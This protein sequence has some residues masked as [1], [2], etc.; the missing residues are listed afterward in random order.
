MP[1]FATASLLLGTRYC[2]SHLEDYSAPSSDVAIRLNP[3]TS[4][5]EKWLLSRLGNLVKS[6]N[7]DMEDFKVADA[8]TSFR[9]FFI[10]DLCDTFIEFSKPGAIT[11]LSLPFLSS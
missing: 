8:A 2:L 1:L 4:L 11:A 3:T 5:L 9:L 7:T 10:N 6:M